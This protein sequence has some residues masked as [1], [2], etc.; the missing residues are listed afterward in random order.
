MIYRFKSTAAG[1][2]IMMAPAGEAVLRII[3]K[4]PAGKGIIE[5]GALPAAIA[6][7]EAAVAADEAARKAAGAEAAAGATA[8][9]GDKVS[10]RQR[11]WP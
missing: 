8:G 11:A 7:L 6:A 9:S 10:L 2:L 4:E 3:G 1:D 5:A